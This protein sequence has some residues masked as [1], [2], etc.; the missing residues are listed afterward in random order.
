MP[1][2]NPAP[3]A[4]RRVPRAPGVRAGEPTE[5]GPLGKPTLAMLKAVGD[6]PDGTPMTEAAFDRLLTEFGVELVDG[7]LDYLPMPYD[8]HAGIVHFLT[9]AFV[10]HLRALDSSAAVR[11]SKIRIRIP[12]WA[13]TDRNTRE[14]DLV[15]LLDPADRRRGEEFWTGADLCVEVVSP[16]DPD[17][18]HVVKRPEYAAAGIPEYWIVDPRDRTPADDRGRTVRVLTLDGAAYRERVFGEGEAAAGELLPGFAV[19]VAACLA[20]A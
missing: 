3:P 2:L 16:D 11:G 20:G 10:D 18:D 7:R 1:L 13:R 6:P 8:L 14:P 9:L 12:E 17:R 4:A 5:C 15:L 19:D